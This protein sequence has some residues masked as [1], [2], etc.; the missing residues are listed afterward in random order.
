MLWYLRDMYLGVKYH[1]MCNYQIVQQKVYM[2]VYIDVHM[3]IMYAYMFIYITGNIC[4][5]VWVWV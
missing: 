1:D 3:Y 2:Y 5:Y 4:G